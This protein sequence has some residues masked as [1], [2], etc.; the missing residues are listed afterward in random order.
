[1]LEIIDGKIKDNGVD[2]TD[3]Y[4]L[5]PKHVP[6][7]NVSKRGVSYAPTPKYYFD[8]EISYDP[9]KKV[10]RTFKIGAAVS[11]IHQTDSGEQ[12]TDAPPHQSQRPACRKQWTGTR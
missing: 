11:G 3:K 1:M 7:M 9:P 10:W 5:D 6:Y 12:W 8:V 2:V 4:A